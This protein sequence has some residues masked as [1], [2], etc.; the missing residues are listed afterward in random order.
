MPFLLGKRCLEPEMMDQPDMAGERHVHALRGLERINAWSGS[1]RLLWPSLAQLARAVSGTVRVLDVATGAGDLPIR[2]WN[3]ARRSGLAIEL[4]GMD[5]SASAIDHA[6]RR[7]VEQGANVNFFVSDALGA[8]L[9]EGYDAIMCSLFLHHL[10]EA[11]AI[12][13]LRQMAQRARRLVL[14]NDLERRF[15]GFLMAWL[16]TRILSRSRVVHVDGPLSV[17]AAFTVP[18]VANI[19][20]RVGLRKIRIERR[21]PCRFVLTA[22]GSR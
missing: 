8:C 12:H 22:R 10:T 3:R 9:P 2:L 11:E 15:G 5:R 18:E 4:D 6:R 14:V 7:A 21:W 19:A 20:E 1:A 17:Q 13:L 16:G